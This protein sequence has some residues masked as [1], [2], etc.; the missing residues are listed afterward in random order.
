MKSWYYKATSLP[1]DF[2]IRAYDASKAFGP[3]NKY[4]YVFGAPVNL[5][6]AGDGWI[7]A[8]I[9]NADNRWTVK[10]YQD[11]T[12]VG[13]MTPVSSR[14][15]WALYHH[16]EELGK[17]KGSNFDKSTNHFYKGQLTGKASEANFKIEARDPFGNVYTTSELK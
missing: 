12:E 8:N 1:A 13:N 6:L 5:S 3:T 15:Y 11:G 2:Q 17:A 10:L 14:D 16:L 9:W 4:T 7:V